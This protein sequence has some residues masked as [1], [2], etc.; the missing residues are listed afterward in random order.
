MVKI[1]LVENNPLQ[2]KCLSDL[3]GTNGYEVF[4]VCGGNE[5]LAVLEKAKIDIA[6]L[7]IMLPDI[8]GIELARIL[9]GY[10][11]SLPIIIQTEKKDFHHKA[12]AFSAGADDYLVKPYDYH[13]I[14]LRIRALLRRSKIVNENTIFTGLT[15]LSRETWT[16]ETAREKLMMPKKEF[17]LLFLLLSYP[18]RIFTRRE[19]LEQIWGLDC[20]TDERTV[21]VHIKRIR[22]RISLVTELKISTIRG[23]GYSAEVLCKKEKT[24]WKTENRMTAGN[25]FRL[26]VNP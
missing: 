14:L 24:D 6:I 23:V 22:K 17:E 7:A 8:D 9:R 26:G 11:K 4:G 19:I 25:T 16:V 21:D 10:D 5:A 18:G 20:D 1:L 12:A 15:K 3:F 13:E 2:R